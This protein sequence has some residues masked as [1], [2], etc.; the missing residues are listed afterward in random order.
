M[1]IE[2]ISFKITGVLDFLSSN[3]MTFQSP[4]RVTSRTLIVID[5]SYKGTTYKN[6]TE[7]MDARD[8]KTSRTLGTRTKGKSRESGILEV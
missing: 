2:E 5:S 4:P 7:V 3:Y 8:G 6:Y 1:K